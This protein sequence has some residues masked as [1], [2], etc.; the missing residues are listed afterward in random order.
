MK[1]AVIQGGPSAEAEVSRRSAAAVALALGAGGHQA[2][3][4]ELD[5]SLPGALHSGQFDV[6][7]PTAHGAL[8]EDGC[9]QGLLEI[10]GFPYVGS[11]VLGSATAADKAR[12]KQLYRL[13][14]LPVVPELLVDASEILRLCSDSGWL[15]MVRAL[16]GDDIIVKPNGGGSTIGVARLLGGYTADV[17]RVAL[18][19]AAQVSRGVLL[20]QFFRGA[21][22]TCGVLE[23]DGQVR[24]LPPTLLSGQISGWSDFRSKYS[25]QGSTHECPAPIPPGLTEKIQHA[26]LLAHRALGARDLS[27]TDV[28]LNDS[29]EFILLETN[30]APGMTSVSLFPEAAA[31]SGIP[32][33]ELVDR[34]VRQAASRKAERP[35]YVQAF[36][37]V[38]PGGTET[39]V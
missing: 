39:I 15:A 9:L 27:R 19:A 4:L 36:P 7:F 35:A 10:L 17:L 12:T 26:A 2:V 24:A 14:G 5:E 1:V 29:G 33:P 11:G 30:T 23:L 13:A 18:E 28:L 16:L 37:T 6:V 31:V 22:L 21:E 25:P 32:F 34:L 8:G 20:E 3:A 38:G